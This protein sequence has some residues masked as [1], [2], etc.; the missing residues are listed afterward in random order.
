MRLADALINVEMACLLHS[1][2]LQEIAVGIRYNPHAEA[3]F[4]YLN[5]PI[6]RFNMRVFIARQH[7]DARYCYSKSVRLSVR[8]SVRNVPVS[9]EN[10]STYR[11]SFFIIQ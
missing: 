10:G 8:L 4:Q 5:I 2:V 3:R 1:V 7:T 11:H 6:F 9:D